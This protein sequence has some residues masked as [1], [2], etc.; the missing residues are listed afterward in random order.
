[1]LRR[2]WG[3]TLGST[4]CGG[5]E[6]LSIPA[7]ASQMPQVA[8]LGDS[9][10]VGAATHPELYFDAKSLWQRFQGERAHQP[11]L[12]FVTPALAAEFALNRDW[13]A[14]QRP[15]PVVSEYGG[16]LSWIG[17]HLSQFI[18]RVY[19]DLE[20]FSWS[21]LWAK[22]A[23]IQPRSLIIAAQDGARMRHAIGQADRILDVTQGQLPKTIFV[24]FTG[25]D[26]CGLF[27]D[28]MTE[29]EVYGAQALELVRY[30]AR[31]GQEAAGGTDIHFLAPLSSMMLRD[32]PSIQEK[33]VP[34]FGKQMTCKDLQQQWPGSW[35]SWQEDMALTEAIAIFEAVRFPKGPAHLC[36]TLFGRNLDF[37]G[38]DQYPL[39]ANR[40][41]AYRQSLADVAEAWREGEGKQRAGLRV[42]Y[43]SA[44][45]EMVLEGDDIANDCFHLSIAGQAK[46]ARMIGDALN[47]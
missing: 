34:A 28:A 45:G 8:V 37:R 21:Y 7:M 31:N 32:R 24:F 16:P 26:L 6:L 47:R 27:I 5:V 30:L 46:L 20:E 14:P 18:G 25:N 19:L 1:M 29:A 15:W 22:K 41:R 39:I 9:I 42:H 35:G 36:P 11:E 3:L 38:S 17:L 2:V 10:S 12:G 44:P 4:L 13:Q 23:Q 43:L 33:M 40:I